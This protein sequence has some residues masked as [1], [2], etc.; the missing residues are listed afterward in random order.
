ME[1]KLS[2]VAI[3]TDKKLSLRKLSSKMFLLCVRA[4]LVWRYGM[5]QLS[6]DLPFIPRTKMQSRINSTVYDGASDIEM[7][8]YRSDNH[9]MSNE[10]ISYPLL[11]QTLF[12]VLSW[13]PLYIVSQPACTSLA[14]SMQKPGKWCIHVSS[15]GHKEHHFRGKGHF[16]NGVPSTGSLCILKK[17]ALTIK[18]LFRGIKFLIMLRSVGVYWF[19]LM[20]TN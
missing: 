13:G 20:F 16:Y 18:Y 4:S 15:N 17:N 9:Q 6:K 12:H 5:C 11:C 1:T 2:S 10:S 14:S 7:Y 3:F 19:R 8:I